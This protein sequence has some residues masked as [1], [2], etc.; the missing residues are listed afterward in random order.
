MLNSVTEI[1]NYAFNNNRLTNIVIPNSVTKI[2]KNVFALNQLTNI[3]MS[4]RFRS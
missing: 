2:G 1:G 3:I 4:K